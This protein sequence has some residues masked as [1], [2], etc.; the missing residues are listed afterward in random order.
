MAVS[1]FLRPG[2]LMEGVQRCLTPDVVQSASSLTGEPEAGT[3]RTLFGAVPAI[4]SGLTSLVST[5][6]GA[7]SLAGLIRDGGFG[8]AADNPRALFAGGSATNSMLDSGGRL[9]NTIFGSRTSS[10]TNSLAESGGVGPASATK[11][12][13]LTAPLVMGVLAKRATAQGLTTSGLA[14]TLLSEKADIAAALPAGIAQPATG[15]SI[16]SPRSEPARAEHSAQPPAAEPARSRSGRNWMPLVVAAVLAF[17]LLMFVRSRAPRNAATQGAAIAREALAKIDLPGGTS[18]SVP[19]GSINYNLARFLGDNAAQAPKTF[20]FDH[21]NF[22]TN[23]TRLTPDSVATVNDL[24]AVLKAYPNAQ[25]ELVGHTDNTGTPDSNRALSLSRADA[26]K[27]TLVNSGVAAERI[28]TK[29]AG[30]DQPLTSNDTEDG[31]ARNRRLELNVT[32]K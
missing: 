16:V 12:L 25:V 19:E 24:A 11:L 28:A 13:S 17:A 14:N 27:G 18:I 6:D 26:V 7:S 20:V 1:Q 8:A 21:L 15:P 5:Q 23:S 4:L 3:R 29:G 22:E 31:R 32:G 2:S 10:V 30:Q 9:L